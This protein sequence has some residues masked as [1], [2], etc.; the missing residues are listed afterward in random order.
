MQGIRKNDRVYFLELGYRI[1]GI[2][3][4][5]RSKKACN[6]SSIEFM[7]DFSLGHPTMPDRSLYLE[8]RLQNKPGGT[9]LLWARPG[10][11]ARIE[12]VDAVK[13]MESVD[14]LINRFQIGDQ[15]P[16]AVSMLQVAFGIC[17][18]VEDKS[19]IK[20]KVRKI[21]EVLHMYDE[22]G[23]DLLYYLTDYDSLE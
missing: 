6:Y 11:V 15:V 5:A 23:N 21:N 4:W 20:E 16:Q 18:V 22:E 7:V 2:G 13:R 8:K 3:A 1:D 9:Y 12:G 14:L 10:K 19:N 17:L